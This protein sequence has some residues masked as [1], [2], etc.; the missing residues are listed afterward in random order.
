MANGWTCCDGAVKS[1]GANEF[2]FHSPGMLVGLR[3]G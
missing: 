1:R 2:F 3:L